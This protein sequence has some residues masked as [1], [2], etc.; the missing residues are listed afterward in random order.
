MKTSMKTVH[1]SLYTNHA[2]ALVTL[3]FGYDFKLFGSMVSRNESM[4]YGTNSL[5]LWHDRRLASGGLFGTMLPQTPA[6]LVIRSWRMLEN[7]VQASYV[8]P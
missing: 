3:A 6:P 4:I 5:N 2:A 7:D 8:T 1:A